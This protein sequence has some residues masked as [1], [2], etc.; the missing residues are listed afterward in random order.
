MS[1]S[2]FARIATRLRGL[3]EADREWLL[4]QL[5]P[6]DGRRLL[7]ALRA[8]RQQA[9]GGSTADRATQRK[10]QVTSFNDGGVPWNR[11]TTASAAEVRQVLSD[12]PDWAIAIVLS[13]QPWQWSQ[14]VL[15]SLAPERIRALRALSTELEGIKARVR[16]VV[17]SEIAA[18]LE[19][20]GAKAPAAEAFDTALERAIGEQPMASRRRLERA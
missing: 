11:L 6:E 12:Q 8:H 15:G 19:R 2:A 10:S 14:E 7:E 4:G 9:A 18:K 20:V 3:S 16:E 13:A 1:E 5:A 17:L